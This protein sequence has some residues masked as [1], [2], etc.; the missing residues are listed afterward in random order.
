[1]SVKC[2]LFLSA[3]SGFLTSGALKPREARARYDALITDPPEVQEEIINVHNRL[4]RSVDPPARNMLKMEWSPEAAYN[5]RILARYCD[6]V[7]SDPME[8]RLSNTFC[9]ENV[10]VESTPIP[11]AEVI[12][13]WYNESRYFKY[14]EW[15]TMNEDTQTNHYTQVV[16]AS[17]FLLGCGVSSCRKNREPQ[18]IYICHYCHEGNNPDMINEPYKKGPWCEDCP[19]NCEDKLCTNPCFYFDEFQGC[20]KQAKTL[21]CEHPTLKIMCRATCLC[22]TEIK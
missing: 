17:S 11:W 15:T 13:T 7:E 5:A 1:M 2:I 4:R 14:G 18:Y 16:W 9:G 22:T 10:H 6:M 3:A 12:E 19:N 21:G 8:R 20:D